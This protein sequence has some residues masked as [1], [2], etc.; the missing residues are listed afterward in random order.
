MYTLM[1]FK[2]PFN[3]G[4]KLAQINGNIKFPPQD[5]GKF[6]KELIECLLSM[7]KRDPNE[8]I[9]IGEVWSVIDSLKDK[10]NQ[11]N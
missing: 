1:Y 2:S 4:E 11:I 10:L 7:F 6:S 5:S 9:G 8:R 3:P